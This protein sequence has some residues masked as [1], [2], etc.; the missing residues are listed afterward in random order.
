MRVNVLGPA[1]VTRALLPNLR[2]ARDAKVAVVSSLMG[3]FS[4]D[5]STVNGGV[6]EHDRIVSRETLEKFFPW[7]AERA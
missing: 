7:E 5:T 3:S 6:F 4:Y 1:L 2:A